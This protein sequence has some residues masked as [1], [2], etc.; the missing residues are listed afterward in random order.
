MGCLETIKN[1]FSGKAKKKPDGRCKED[2]GGAATNPAPTAT[3]PA[4]QTSKNPKTSLVATTAAQQ[5][6]KNA[7]QS[8]SQAP[9]PLS[10]P[11]VNA[12]PID[13]GPVAL[14][15]GSAI[16]T[17]TRAY[18][19]VLER[20]R[21]LMTDYK[22]HLD[23]LQDEVTDSEDFS[24]PRSIESIVNKLLEDRE[25]K[26][27]QVSLPRN[28]VKIRDQIEKLAKILLWSD[29]V[30]KSALSTQPYAALAWS[31]VSIL[32]PLLTRGTTQNEAMLKGFN[33]ISDLQIYWEIC[34]QT[35]LK[36]ENRKYYQHL[37]M[38]LA[39]LYSYVIE[40]QARVICHLSS[41]QLSRAWQ[42]VAGSNDWIGMLD[43]IENQ[44][45]DCRKRFILNGEQTEIR[46]KWNVQLRKIQ[47][48]EITQEKMLQDVRGNRQDE[49]ET[50]LLQDLADAAKD[51]KRYKDMNPERVPGT[52]EWFLT[53]ERF[54]KWRDSESSSL[55]W[56]SAGP[57][58][59]KSVLS[60]CLID[61]EKLSAT[62]TITVTNSAILA[63]SE[64]IICYFFFK[65]G[66]AGKMDGT[67]ALCAILHQLFTYPSTSGQIKHALPRHKENGAILTRKFSELWQILVECATSSDTKEIICVLDA[68]DECEEI[69][70]QEIIRT[71]RGFYSHNKNLSSQSSKLKFLVTSRPYDDLE[72][73]FQKFPATVAYLR[74]DGDEKSK[75]IG[76]EIDL[77]IDAKVQDIAAGFTPDDRQKISKRLKSMENRTYLWLHLTFKIIEGR[78]TKYGRRSDVEK[79]LS[80]IPSEVFDAYE[81]ILSRSRDPLR[82]EMLLQIVLAAEQPLTLDE[83]NVALTLASAERFA[84][85]RALKSDLWPRDNFRSIVMNLCGLLISVYDSKLSFIHQTAREFLIHHEEQGTWKG[86]FR[87]SVSH[88]R[89]SRLCLR[90]LLLPDIN[91]LVRDSP[92]ILFKNDPEILD[93]DDSEIL[94]GDD[95]ERNGYPFLFYAA[96]YWSLH[97]TSQEAA[98]ADKFRKDAHML[99]KTFAH[100][101]KYW[102][103]N[104]FETA[105]RYKGSWTDLVLASYLGL[106]PVVQEILFQK[107]TADMQKVDYGAALYA[108]SERG[109][110]EIVQMLLESNADVNAIFGKYGTALI[111]ASL[112]GDQEI[113]QIL[114]NRGADINVIS[115]E[116]GTALTVASL[117]GYQKIVQMLLDRGADIN[118]IA[119]T[120]GTALI[121]ASLKGEQKIVQILLNRGADINVTS[122]D[123]GTALIAAS[124]RG[125]PK[126]VQ[127]LLNHGAAAT[128]LQKWFAVDEGDYSADSGSNVNTGIKGSWT[129]ARP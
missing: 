11:P 124:D 61:E 62:S 52:C 79:L 36:S 10:T 109:H 100:L 93:G 85:Y 113:V 84:S 89:L 20:E 75:Q 5:P 99:C 120:L 22:K 54:R 90:Y 27:W 121:A 82:A 78:P 32:L 4:T 38:P 80:D 15:K 7:A 45:K 28:N 14:Q 106:T 31:G 65:E 29:P 117:V 91:I 105:Y 71:L 77:V 112:S 88:S 30:V 101:A 8:V 123:Y 98:V 118:M 95:P 24:T 104:R 35:Y 25:K 110:Q 111:A 87:S 18:E 46:N 60:R 26:Q 53:D 69:S 51:Y 115:K 50:R 34:E 39:K 23:S 96:T 97:Y 125:H 40:Y 68:L 47:K 17:W 16:D 43:K 73:A 122:E 128:E 116:Y 63:N 92:N 13:A 3:R 67:Q 48:L 42:N 2:H 64:S 94:D 37:A 56:V 107:K 72:R 6:P 103:P 33:W 44:D 76:Q 59:G 127:M 49:K 58:R 102:M 66:G 126:I 55:L 83:A 41:A 19:I 12:Q 70:R 108:A 9:A 57:G 86:R 119:G 74:F 114:L 81:S 21:E 129:V 1:C